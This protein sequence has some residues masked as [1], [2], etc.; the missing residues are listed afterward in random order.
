MESSRPRYFLKPRVGD[1]DS[2]GDVYNRPVVTPKKARLVKTRTKLTVPSIMVRH[3]AL[4]LV[5]L[6]VVHLYGNLFLFNLLVVYPKDL[7]VLPQRFQSE[8]WHYF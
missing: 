8:L 1:S 3:W 6:A 5:V 7:V 4:G 2:E